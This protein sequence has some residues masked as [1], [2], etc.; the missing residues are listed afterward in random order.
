MIPF[1]RASKEFRIGR[2]AFGKIIPWFSLSWTALSGAAPVGGTAP[3]IDIWYG[4][5]QRVGHLG[6][7]QED[8]NL[9]GHIDSWRELDTL[10]WSLNERAPVPLNF[11]VYR[12]LAAEGDFNADIPL[13]RLRAGENSINLT[14]RWRDGRTVSRMVTISREQGSTPLPRFIHWASVPNPQDAGQI[15]DGLWSVTPDGLRTVLT[16]YDRIFLI[17]ENNWRDYDV[18]TSI[19]VHRAPDL[20]ESPGVGLI[21]RFTGHVVGGPKHFPSGQPKWGY[22]PFG[23]I[24]WIRWSKQTPP[25]S[26][27]AQYFPGSEGRPTDLKAVA[28]MVGTRYDLRVT[29]KTL[30]DDAEGRGVTHYRFKIWPAENSE[31]EA[32]TWERTQTSATALRSGGVALLA[33][34]VDV[35][36]GDVTVLPLSSEP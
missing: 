31:P 14:A 24:A 6:T 1:T 3:E 27:Q 15:V 32:W 29:C 28:F 19:R 35:T 18:R 17:G 26:P 30:P 34:K 22:Q 8:F 23:T 25:S 5:R 13:G 7:A 4:E 16:G 33:H 21:A 9:L 36:F 10:E 20:S 12:R 2:F 11:R